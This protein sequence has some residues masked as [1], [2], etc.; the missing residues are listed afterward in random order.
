MGKSQVLSFHVFGGCVA[1]QCQIYEL[2]DNITYFLIV[3]LSTFSVKGR[4]DLGMLD[5]S[6]YMTINHSSGFYTGIPIVWIV[7]YFK[8][9]FKLY[10]NKLG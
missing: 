7:W 2:N 5:E 1:S 9:Y 6:K 4:L 8:Q 3:Q 10:Q